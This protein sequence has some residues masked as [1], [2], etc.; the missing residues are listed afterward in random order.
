MERVIRMQ[1]NIEIEPLSSDERNMGMLCHL[2]ALLG[3][4]GIPFGNIIGPLVIWM[5]KKEESEFIDKCGQ[6]SL[7]FQISMFI[8]GAISGVL[9]LV[10][11]GI[12][13]LIAILI[14]DLVCV[15]QASITASE[16]RVY[17]YPFTM[18]FVS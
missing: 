7:N 18:R 1:D 16:G 10:L 8:Y 12:P 4:I 11:I 5:V 6:E 13:M 9:I 15:I 2:L 17:H 14:I 3:Y